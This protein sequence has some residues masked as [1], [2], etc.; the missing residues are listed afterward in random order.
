MSGNL[1]FRKVST[2][3]TDQSGYLC[4]D[5]ANNMICAENMLSF[6]DSGILVHTR[7]RVH[8]GSFPGENLG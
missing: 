7:Q 5:G 2:T 6:W 4:L 1:V 8:M 3:L